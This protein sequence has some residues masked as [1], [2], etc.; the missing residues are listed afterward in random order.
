MPINTSRQ[1]PHT[2]NAGQNKKRKSYSKSYHNID[3]YVMVSFD[4]AGDRQTT[5]INKK[6]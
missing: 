5:K 4:T 6:K 2:Q 3:Q 1:K